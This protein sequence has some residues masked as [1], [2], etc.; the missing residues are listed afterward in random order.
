MNPHA[1]RFYNHAIDQPLANGT[2]PFTTLLLFDLPIALHYDGVLDKP[3]LLTTLCRLPSDAL[4]FSVTLADDL[5][6]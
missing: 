1:A 3:P 6:L 2:T 5:L 4:R